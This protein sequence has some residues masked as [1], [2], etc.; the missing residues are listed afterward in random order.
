MKKR[1]V[2]ALLAVTVLLSMAACGQEAA[3]P[4]TDEVATEETVT[5]TEEKTKE[6]KTEEEEKDNGELNAVS[7]INKAWD[8]I[9]EDKKFPVM[10]GDFDAPVDGKAGK[11]NIKNV[12]N[13]T[14]T[15][16]ITEDS[17]GK[18]QDAAALTHMM[19]ANTFTCAAYQ[20]KSEDAAD[21][22]SSLKDSIKSTQW[23]CGQPETLII[24]T[25]SEEYVVAAFGNGEAIGYFET[26]LTDV[27]G[28]DAVENV[29]EPLV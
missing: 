7:V 3:N 4:T 22:V 23:M 16:H 18:V 9:D 25:V 20:V 5:A 6:V 10:G 15:L 17:L 19:N 27:F 13:T 26:A 21:L 1:I 12:E 2:L 14:N 11:V 29:K 24:Y 28:S 8:K